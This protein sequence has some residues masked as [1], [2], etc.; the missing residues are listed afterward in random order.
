MKVYADG[1]QEYETESIRLEEGELKFIEV[2]L[3]ATR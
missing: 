1:F 3:H 2:R